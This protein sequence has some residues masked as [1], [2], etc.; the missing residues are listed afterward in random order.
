[1][2]GPELRSGGEPKA[3]KD[4]EEENIQMT[5]NTFRISG[6]SWHW[7]ADISNFNWD[8]NS[9]PPTLSFTLDFP[10]K[11]TAK[12][13]FTG[14]GTAKPNLFQLTPSGSNSFTIPKSEHFPGQHSAGN[15]I[16]DNTTALARGIVVTP[17]A[18]NPV[19]WEATGSVGVPYQMAQGAGA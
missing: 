10:D 19:E 7:E 4:Q 11:T 13:S 3:H 2:Q 15:G 5:S 1:L 17:G 18:G 8:A 14:R 12:L 16:Y 9:N 6:D